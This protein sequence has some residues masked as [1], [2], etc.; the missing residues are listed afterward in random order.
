MKPVVVS[1]YTEVVN[2]VDEMWDEGLLEE[3]CH[4]DQR[5]NYGLLGGECGKS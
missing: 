1:N 3:D 4:F 5:G 2:I